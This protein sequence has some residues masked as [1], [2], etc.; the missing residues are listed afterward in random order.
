MRVKILDYWALGIPVVATTIGAEGLVDAEREVVA[1]GDSAVAF[2]E[3]I[4][5]LG[6]RPDVRE[7]I[8]TA[9]F[10]KVQR[11][12]SWS[13]I[14]SGLLARYGQMLAPKP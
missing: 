6:S 9:A 12:Y 10:D 1:I 7:A 8:R 2:A 14:I 13:G 3:A 4:V 11:E 5:R